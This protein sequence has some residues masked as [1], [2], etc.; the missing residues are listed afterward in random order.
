MRHYNKARFAVKFVECNGEF[1]SIMD[2]VRNDMVIEMN[3]ANTYDHVPEA[4]RNN[5]V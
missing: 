1:K 3:D 2:E 5:I 4:Y